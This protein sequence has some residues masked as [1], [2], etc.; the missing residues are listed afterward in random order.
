VGTIDPPE[1]PLNEPLTRTP[2]RPDL[3]EAVCEYVFRFRAVEQLRRTSQSHAE[4]L[5]IIDALA[6]KDARRAGWLMRQ[7]LRAYRTAAARSMRSPTNA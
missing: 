2:P 5:A 7:H 3:R 4:H 6:A 1:P